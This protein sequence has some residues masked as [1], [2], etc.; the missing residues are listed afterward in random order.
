MFAPHPANRRR[1]FA[2]KNYLM[3]WVEREGCPTVREAQS[4]FTDSAKLR[5]HFSTVGALRGIPNHA[6]KKWTICLRNSKCKLSSSAKKKEILRREHHSPHF[7]LGDLAL[8]ARK[9]YH[10]KPH[11]YF[12]CLPCITAS[13]QK[14][15]NPYM[16]KKI[17]GTHGGPWQSA[18]S[19]AAFMLPMNNNRAQSSESSERFIALKI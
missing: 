2:M 18:P 5:R 4:F 15:M 11:F 1:C 6:E 3:L 8:H 7:S 14:Q 16:T 17:G 10:H 12:V 19:I 13:A 9:M